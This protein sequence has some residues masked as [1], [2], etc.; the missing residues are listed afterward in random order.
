[1]TGRRKLHFVPRKM[2][3]PKCILTLNRKWNI[4]DSENIDW[5]VFNF[6]TCEFLRSLITNTTT[7]MV[8]ELLS[9]QSRHVSWNSL[10]TSLKINGN[11]PPEWGEGVE[12]RWSWIM[13][14]QSSPK[15]LVPRLDH[16]SWSYMLISTKISRNSLLGRF[17]SHWSWISWL[18]LSPKCLVP[19]VSLVSWSYMLTSLKIQSKLFT[20]SIFEVAYH[21]YHDGDG[22]WST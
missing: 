22:L 13:I 19:R 21:Q 2:Y 20:G 12:G 4:C 9:A 8:S 7:V 17:E 1:M 5:N 18:R 6:A 10:L 14:R 15:Y 11:S 16:V 3:C